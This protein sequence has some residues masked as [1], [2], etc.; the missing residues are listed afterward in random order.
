MFPLGPPVLSHLAKGAE[1]C[2]SHG[3]FQAPP[4]PLTFSMLLPWCASSQPFPFAASPFPSGSLPPPSWPSEPSFCPPPVL[5]AWPQT[6]VISS[7]TFLVSEAL[8]PSD[9]SSG[10]LSPGQEEISKSQIGH[11]RLKNLR[12]MIH[13]QG[14]SQSTLHMKQAILPVDGTDW[15]GSALRPAKNSSH[16]SEVKPVLFDGNKLRTDCHG[17]FSCQSSKR[18]K[19]WRDVVKVNSASY[20]KWPMCTQKHSNVSAILWKS[21]LGYMPP[22]QRL[23]K[24]GREYWGSITGLLL[25]SYN[26]TSYSF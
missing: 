19:T 20:C 21:I 22:N 23:L 11:Q 1:N 4:F 18:G 5:G 13:W 26:D 14:G 24:G 9:A 17:G 7:G 10:F 8:M 6:E 2:S 3:S 25:S 16:E 12:F 15:T